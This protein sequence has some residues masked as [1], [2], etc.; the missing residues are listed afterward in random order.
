MECAGLSAMA[1]QVLNITDFYKDPADLVHLDWFAISS[2]NFSDSKVKEGK[3]AEF[4]MFDVFPWRLVDK[5][6]TVNSTIATKVQT[7]LANAGH[8]PKIVPEPSWYF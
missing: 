7:A 1:M 4:L 6:G 5:I 8:Q 3:Q 2:N